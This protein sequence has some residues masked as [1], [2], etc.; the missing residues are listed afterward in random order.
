MAARPACES[1]CSGPSRLLPQAGEVRDLAGAKGAR[2][3]VGIQGG[4][5][6]PAWA[7]GRRAARRASRAASMLRL[8]AELGACALGRHDR[9]PERE[10]EPARRRRLQPERWPAVT[11]ART[12]RR[13]S[14]MG[15]APKTSPSSRAPSGGLGGD[16][17]GAVDV[18]EHRSAIGIGNV[19]GVHALDHQP[20]RQREPAHDR[21]AHQVAG[22]RPA[23]RRR[24]RSAPGAQKTS[25]GRRR[26]T[27][28]RRGRASKASRSRS[29]CALCWA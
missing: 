28:D 21:G 23:K 25:A 8:P 29:I 27:R 22:E 10:V 12:R 2:L 1:S 16:V 4:V 26:T 14:S 6:P 13:G 3:A 7:R 11:A 5:G 17:E 15:G 19:A 20:S 18:R 24:P 9:H